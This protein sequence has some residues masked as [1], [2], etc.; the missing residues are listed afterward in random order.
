M[1]RIDMK[2]LSEIWRYYQAGI[3][4]TAFGY[5]LFSFLVW[6]NLNIFIAQIVSHSCGTVF[7]YFMYTKHVFRSSEPVKGKFFVSYIGNYFLSLAA[8]AIATRL[9]PSPYAAGFVSI[10]VVSLINY[11]ILKRLVFSRPIS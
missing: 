6:I 9:V 1:L 4:N 3:L 2:D 5:G 7:N 11:V 10:I 8:L